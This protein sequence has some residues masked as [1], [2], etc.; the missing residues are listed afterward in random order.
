MGD[1]YDRIVVGNDSFDFV[2]GPDAF[3]QR[4]KQYFPK[5]AGVIDRYVSRIREVPRWAGL[6]F[7]EKALPAPVAALGGALMR[8]PFLRHARRTTRST[9]E[10]MGIGH[11]LLGVLTGQWGDYGLPPGQSSFVMHAI[12]AR[13]YLR[14]GFYPVGGASQIAASLVPV[15]EAS[16]GRILVAAEV[17]QILVERGRASGVR[18]ADGT[19]LKSPLVVSDAGVHTTFGRLLPDEHAQGHG[20][21]GRLRRLRPSLAHA[22]LYVGFQRSAEELGLPKTNLWLYPGFDHDANVEAF[23][24]DPEAPLPVVYTSF[25]SAK[26]PS[27]GE[28]YPG[29]A[30]VEL[31]TLAPFE[32]FARWK[33]E[34]WRR[35]GDEYEALKQ[36]L[37]ERMLRR[38]EQQLPGLSEQ[39][40]V[41]EL[42]TPL[43]TRHFANYER[44]E[45]Y[46]LEHSPGR[47]AE[48]ALRPRTPIRGLFLTG[49]DV[50]TCGIAGALASG[51]LT[52]S[53]IL[54]RN[55]IAVGSK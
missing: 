29:R 18:M 55:L 28:R 22:C 12:L 34:P 45:I 15:I 42:S 25:P 31:I 16:G 51:Y 24:Q 20:V 32:Q 54:G 26:D 11:E 23:A 21:A 3:R 47:F 6:Y 30:T 50:A 19:E 8:W 37:T 5:D 48:R 40:D 35:R 44:G 43:S 14:G 10:G 49:Q 2:A 27:F 52:A 17:Q 4:L 39:I 38:L 1:A 7:A 53:A 41:A 33:D 13:H 9:L 46:G 36:R